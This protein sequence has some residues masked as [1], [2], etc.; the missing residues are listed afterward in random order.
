M[1]YFKIIQNDNE[2]QKYACI[3]LV[4]FYACLYLEEGDE[5]YERY[6]K[7]C[8]QIIYPPEGYLGEVDGE[9]NPV[10]KEDYLKWESALP[11]MTVPFV[12]HQIKFEPWHTEEEILWCFEWALALS[13]K[14]WLLDDLSCNKG[15]GIKI[16][17]Y[18]TGKKY[19]QRITDYKKDWNA[20]TKEVNAAIS[21]SMELK[22]VDFTTAKTSVKYSVK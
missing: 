2:C 12:I 1:G 21:R 10:D 17:T 20:K 22:G 9:G 13:H 14:N 3:G 8:Y 16:N 15:L 19:L 11:R 6:V 5:G 7:E 4:P 18:I